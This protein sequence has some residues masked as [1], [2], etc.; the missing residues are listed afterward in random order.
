M[1][2]NNLIS[3]SFKVDFYTL[4]TGASAGLGKQIAIESAKWGFNLF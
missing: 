3:D 4:I 1:A 2:K